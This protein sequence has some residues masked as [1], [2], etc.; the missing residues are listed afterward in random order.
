MDI[1]SQKKLKNKIESLSKFYQTQILE[2]LIKNHVKYSENRNGIF[3]NMNHLNS[4][5]IKQINDKLKYINEQEKTLKNIENV[6]EELNKDFFKG[7]KDNSTSN[8]LYYA[9]E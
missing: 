5:I 1:N 6:K 3:L 2:I 8:T 9:G 4:D 7:N